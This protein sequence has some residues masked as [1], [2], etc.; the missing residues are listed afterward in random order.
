[1]ENASAGPGAADQ[2]VVSG[3]PTVAAQDRNEPGWYPDTT[4]PGLM[5]YW[6]GFHFTGQAKRASSVE[7]STGNAEE[8]VESV[9]PLATDVDSSD[10]GPELTDLDLPT[11]FAPGAG[12]LPP[13]FGGNESVA[14]STISTLPVPAT[15]FP[16]YVGETPDA[17][18]PSLQAEPDQVEPEQVEPVSVEPESV[19]PVSVEPVSVEPGSVVSDRN[20]EPETALGGVLV[21]PAEGGQD[22]TATEDVVVPAGNESISERDGLRGKENLMVSLQG[23]ETPDGVNNLGKDAELAVARA[24]SVDTPEAW[25]QAGNVAAVVADMAQ[26][27]QAAADAKQTATQTAKAADEAAEAARAAAQTA[28]DAKQAA[29]RMAK[30]AEDAAEAARA[31]AQT[32]VEAKKAAARTAEAAPKVAES[33]EV[34]SQTAAV[35][36]QK[37]QALE[38]VVA[39][40]RSANTPAAWSEALGLV[41]SACRQRSLAA[42]LSRSKSQTT[43]HRLPSE[44]EHADRRTGNRADWSAVRDPRA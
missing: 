18:D 28:A 36:K 22:A 17:L 3:I 19:E 31:A 25:Q 15:Y 1:M 4:D 6:D 14:P 29:E 33:A 41:G 27:M 24:L 11:Q 37:A 26:T 23:N 21:A 13:L 5:R 35:A 9:S 43:R 34:A 20:L 39:T 30:A 10:G 44:A 16:L 42:E 38:Q 2:Q 7:W 12:G 32:A 8:V 40:A